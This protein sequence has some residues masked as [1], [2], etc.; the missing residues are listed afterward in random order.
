MVPVRVRLYST[1]TLKELQEHA[2]A[3]PGSRAPRIDFI[4]PLTGHKSRDRAPAG[5][6]S[7]RVEFVQRHTHV[8]TR[9]QRLPSQAVFLGEGH[10]IL[11]GLL[12]AYMVEILGNTSRH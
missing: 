1:D 2:S 8:H 9:G 6:S 10:M 11:E 7:E 12:D 3:E 5:W 4:N